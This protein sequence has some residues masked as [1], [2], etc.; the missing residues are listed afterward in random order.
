MRVSPPITGKQAALLRARAWDAGLKGDR[1]FLEW[2]EYESGFRLN[3]GKVEEVQ[4]CFMD[5]ILKKLSER[6]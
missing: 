5:G 2:L 3:Y 1:A 6:A 4:S